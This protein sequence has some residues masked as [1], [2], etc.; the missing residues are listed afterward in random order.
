MK[1]QLIAA[2]IAATAAL[3]LAGCTASVEMTEESVTVA[4]QPEETELIAET[5]TEAPAATEGPEDAFLAGVRDGLRDDTQIP[6]ATDGQLLAA[7]ADACAQ[8]AAGA[9]LETITVIDGETP[10]AA[11]YFVDSMII[12]GN[13]DGTLC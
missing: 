6:G 7:G 13:A 5:S 4:P 9:A 11:G 2:T 3:L 8:M 12:A 1:R 10:D